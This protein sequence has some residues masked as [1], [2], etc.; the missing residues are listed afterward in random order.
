MAD[1][2][3]TQTLAEA[4]PF[5]TVHAMMAFAAAGSAGAAMRLMD[6]LPRI[7]ASVISSPIPEEAL[8]P[9]FCEALLAF[10]RCDLSDM[11]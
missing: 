11:P 3:E 2:W 10:T 1:H 7:G 5:Y 4:R 9:P 8:A 6:T